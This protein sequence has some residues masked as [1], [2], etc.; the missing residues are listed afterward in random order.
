[1]ERAA[2]DPGF[3]NSEGRRLCA[4]I[5][6][7]EES[8][9]SL[10]NDRLEAFLWAFL[11]MLKKNNYEK[12]LIKYHD[13]YLDILLSHIR[14]DKGIIISTQVNTH[15][16]PSRPSRSF[17]GDGDVPLHGQGIIFTV[18][19]IDR[20]YL[21]RPNWLL[22]GLLRLSQGFFPDFPAGFPAHNVYDRLVISAPA[23]VRPYQYRVCIIKVLVRYIVTGCIFYIFCVRR[24]V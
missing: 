15:L 16:W 6:H 11:S 13:T 9:N 3:S 2:A 18:I 1:M 21:N 8:A 12:L 5:A 22:A 14:Y 19:H 17:N 10:I 4:L 24:A 20:G 23:T 7:H